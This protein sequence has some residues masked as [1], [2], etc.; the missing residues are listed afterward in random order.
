[1][2]MISTL[3]DF[4]MVIETILTAINKSE[5]VMQ[6]SVSI[7]YMESERERDVVMEHN[8]KISN[9]NLLPM[10]CLLAF[11]GK[12]RLTFDLK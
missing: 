11:L 10:K 3:F 1:M 5:R 7:R 12:I 8:G 9:H 6:L 2:M 4:T